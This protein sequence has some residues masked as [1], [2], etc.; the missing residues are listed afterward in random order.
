LNAGGSV[1]NSNSNKSS[2]VLIDIGEKISPMIYELTTEASKEKKILS[3]AENPP[4]VF[5]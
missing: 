3:I 4:S 5:C 2:I 1:D